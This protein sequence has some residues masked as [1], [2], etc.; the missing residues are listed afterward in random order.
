MHDPQ[1]HQSSFHFRF[2][3]AT[4][5]VK[6][7]KIERPGIKIYPFPRAYK[8]TGWDL[9]RDI[10]VVV[11]RHVSV[12]ALIQN[13]IRAPNKEIIRYHGIAAI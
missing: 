5:F 7:D 1:P 6:R 12:H 3:V 4:G 9:C 10:I 8:G 2:P 13:C 11:Y